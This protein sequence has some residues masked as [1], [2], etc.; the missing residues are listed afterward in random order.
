MTITYSFEVKPEIKGD[1]LELR[2]WGLNLLKDYIYEA[3]ID[4]EYLQIDIEIDE[5]DY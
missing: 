1:E 2:E 4:D 5:Y 3:D